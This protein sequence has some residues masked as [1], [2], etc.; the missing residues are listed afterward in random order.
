MN[1]GYLACPSGQRPGLDKEERKECVVVENADSLAAPA[2]T[3]QGASKK[4]SS[5]P[6]IESQGPSS[7]W[8][9]QLE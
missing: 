2:V 8:P 9:E 7:R 3:S 6:S 1:I 4:Q 5:Q